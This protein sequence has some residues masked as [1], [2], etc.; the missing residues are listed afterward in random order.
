MNP[1]ESKIEHLAHP[2]PMRRNRAD[3]ITPYNTR[4]LPFIGENNVTYA[5]LRE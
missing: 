4:A 1:P 5:T 2:R 3:Y